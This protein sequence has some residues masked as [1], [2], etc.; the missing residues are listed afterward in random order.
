MMDK[1][2]KDGFLKVWGQLI[3]QSVLHQYHKGQVLFYKGHLP[4]GIFIIVSGQVHLV[5]TEETNPEQGFPA[6]LYNPIGFDLL[7]SRQCYPFTAIAQS[8]VKAVF[9]AKSSLNKLC[10]QSEPVL[11]KKR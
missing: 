9:I 11:E 5:G 10:Q 2:I 1:P 3:E 4:Y 8:D 6:L 7:F